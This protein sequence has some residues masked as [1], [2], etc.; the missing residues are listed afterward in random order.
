M[1]NNFHFDRRI[2]DVRS[3]RFQAAQVF[4][5]LVL[6]LLCASCSNG[7]AANASGAPQAM[8]V[9]VHT[10]ALQKVDDST[11]YVATLKSR[12][13]AVVMPQVEGIITQIFVHSGDRVANGQ[14]LMQ[15]DPTKQQATVQTQE[16]ARAA[17]LAQLTWAK[18]NYERVSGLAS[19]GVVSKQELDQARATLDAAESQLHS[20]DAQV[21]EQQVQLHYYKVVAPRAGIVGDVPVRVGDRVVTTTQL[22]TVDRPGSLEAYIYVPIEKSAELKMNLPVQIVDGSGNLLAS[23][24]ITF[25]S[26]QVDNSTQTVLAKAQIQNSND[27]LRTAQFIRARVVWGTEERPV[28][29]VVAVS[30]IGG[31]Y[32]AFVAEPDQKGGYVV[33]QKPLQIGQIV[34]NDYVVLNGLKPGDK[35]VI[36]GTQFLIDGIPV[37]PQETSSS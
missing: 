10:A 16:N 14:P 5:L 20:L 30:R 8:P 37:V 13:S 28:V 9:K 35:V 19:A 1:S 24:R 18:Q 2:V 12:D 27:A 4:S 31:L 11:E 21:S 36:S 34:A 6:L 3:R 32:F 26:P 17:Q 33:H 25:I 15:I 23:S 7:K 29:P 22:T